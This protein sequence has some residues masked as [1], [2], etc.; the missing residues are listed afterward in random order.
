MSGAA[1]RTD[2]RAPGRGPGRPLRSAAFRRLLVGQAASSLGDWVVTLALAAAAFDMTGSSAA[3]GLVLA[4]R[5]TPALVAAPL[6]GALADRLDRRMVMVGTN[7]VM[8]AL[9]ALAPFVG[10]LGLTAIAFASE[11]LAVLCLPSRD[12]AVPDLVPRGSLARANGLVMASGYA[13]IPVGTVLFSGLQLAGAHVPASAPLSEFLR[14]SPL[15]IPLL[16]SAA[17]FGVAAAVLLGL[18]GSAPGRVSGRRP[19]PAREALRRA[20]AVHGLAPLAAGGAVAALGVAALFVAGTAHARASLG[21]SGVGFGH[22]AAVW[23]LGMGLG[24]GALRPLARRGEAGAFRA[25]LA[26]SG[27]AVGA[28]GL[29]TS[30]W[31]V[32]A[33]ALAFGLGLAVAL[34]LAVTLVQ[35]VAFEDVR[36]RL[37]GGAHMVLQASLAAG[38]LAAGA[39]AA[40]VQGVTLPLGH[41][42]LTLDGS[43]LALLVAGGLLLVGAL[44]SRGVR[45][46]AAGPAAA[47]FRR[48]GPRVGAVPG[49]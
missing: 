47:E 37:L 26:L 39:L 12:A 4:L 14:S 6:G 45:R 9:I 49:R 43:R 33:A 20:R 28:M 36:G 15:A 24:V 25:A 18:P 23:G 7:V 2:G 11:S 1:Y 22:L 3:F 19:V 13:S 31:A 42:G 5:V 8:A 40:S 21:P 16:A 41:A 48:L 32:L 29:A 34:V 30:I 27:L 10:L 17:T 38:A 44:A 46:L 35:R